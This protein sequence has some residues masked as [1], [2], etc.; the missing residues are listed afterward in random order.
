MDDLILSAVTLGAATNQSAYINQALSWWRDSG[1]AGSDNVL[2][3]DS[4]A[5]AIPVMLAQLASAQPQLLPSSSS[6]SNWQN[7]AEG[8]LDRIVNGKS[9]GYLTNGG[10]LYYDG[11]S[12]SVSLNPSLNVAML[13][14]HYAPLA[15]SNEKRN[16]YTV[17]IVILAQVIIGSLLFAVIC[18]WPNCICTGKEPNER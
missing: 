13:M 8:Y 7:E 15:T 1:L 12:D 16:A 14:L 9:R 11:D 10:L 6:L 4:K 18:P 5:P 3:W 17:R 2:N